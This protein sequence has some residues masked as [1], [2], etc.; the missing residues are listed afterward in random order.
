MPVLQKRLHSWFV[1]WLGAQA[2]RALHATW[3]VRVRDPAGV[4]PGAREGAAPSI[5]AF[6]HRHLLTMLA[7][8]GGFRVCVPVSEHQDGEYVAQVMGRF[9]LESVRGSTTH[10][11]LRLLRGML[12]RM[13]E[14]WTAAVTPDGPRGPR[15]SVQRGVGLLAA[16]SG[17]PVHP[18]GLAA[19]SAWVF[20]SWDAFL[21]P[22]PWSRVGIAFGPPL[23][24]EDYGRADAFCGALKEALFAATDEAEA[25][26]ACEDA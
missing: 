2:V 9:G 17:R 7:H 4:R 5:V 19:S 26:V 6:W 24:F 12:E 18:I 11:S 20:P 10:G 25:A 13:D 16:R 15:Y 21:V 8:H 14:G 23:A 3:D 1:G 22:R